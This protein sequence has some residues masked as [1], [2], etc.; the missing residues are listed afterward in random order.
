MS[1]DDGTIDAIAGSERLVLRTP[2]ALCGEDLNTLGGSRS[3]PAS[4]SPLS[5][6]M[7]P[8]LRIRRSRSTLFN[9]LERTESYCCRRQSGAGELRLKSRAN[10][11]RVNCLAKDVD[12]QLGLGRQLS[13]DQA[14]AT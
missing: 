8:H 10:F 4:R 14:G 3:R 2:A 13:S 11:W 6:L 1:I 5:S 9:A 12:L 7:E